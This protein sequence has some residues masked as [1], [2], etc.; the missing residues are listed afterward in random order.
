[1]RHWVPRLLRRRRLLDFDVLTDRSPSFPD[2][3][4]IADGTLAL[5]ENGS[6]K[7]WACLHCPG[8]CVEVINLSL[9]PDRRPR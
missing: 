8:G 3:S 6:I 7:K 4:S 5:V 9:N 2:R 1:M